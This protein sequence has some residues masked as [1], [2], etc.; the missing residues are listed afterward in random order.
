[1]CFAK[2]KINREEKV[3][4]K[5]ILA[6]DDDKLDSTVKIQGTQ[7]DRKRKL[8][9]KD[10]EKIKAKLKKNI[11]VEAIASE[12]N[13]S[14]WIIRYNTDEAFREHQLKLREKKSKTH[15]N[16]MDFEDRVAYKRALVKSKK[17][18]VRGLI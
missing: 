12:F 6:Y 13:V 9:D 5:E 15:I 10:L 16:S 8:S 14:E 4:R 18:S 2:F 7:Y 17:L 3:A 11:P 1:M